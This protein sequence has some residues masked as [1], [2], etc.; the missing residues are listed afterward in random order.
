MLTKDFFIFSGILAVASTVSAHFQMQFPEPR[1]VFV[2]NQEVNFCDGYQNAVSNRTTFPLDQ[3]FVTINSEHPS[4]SAQI[5]ISIDQD[6]TSFSNFNTSSTG[7]QLPSA[8]PFFKAT[9]EGPA[10]IAIDIAN[11]NITGVKDGSNVTIQ[12]QFDGGDGNLFQCADLTL[13]RNATMPSGVNCTNLV[14]NSTTTASNSTSTTGA[15]PT[16]TTN[17]ALLLSGEGSGLLGLFAAMLLA[18]L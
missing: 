18:L 9:G 2:E 4:W 15:Q 12:V 11:L 6:P 5:L 1:G 17:A 3:G 10:C 13:S 8:V 7:V 16:T 14:S